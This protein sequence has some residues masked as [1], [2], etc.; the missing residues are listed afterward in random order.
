MFFLFK[1]IYIV[2]AVQFPLSIPP[3]MHAGEGEGDT[4]HEQAQSHQLHLHQKKQCQ[5]IKTLKKN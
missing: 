2:S 5:I 1:I 4:V 3:F